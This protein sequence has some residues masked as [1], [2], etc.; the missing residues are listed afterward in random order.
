MEIYFLKKTWV[1]WDGWPIGDS[2]VLSDSTFTDKQE[3]WRHAAE[4]GR[5]QDA[6]RN[7]YSY[8]V[9]TIWVPA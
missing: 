8:T 4:L 9:E 2:Q 1:N 7:H 5:N 6:S 3:A